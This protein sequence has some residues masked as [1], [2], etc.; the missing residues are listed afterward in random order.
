VWGVELRP[1]YAIA[2]LYTDA[3]KVPSMKLCSCLLFEG[4]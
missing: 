3:H 2:H 4:N 1:N